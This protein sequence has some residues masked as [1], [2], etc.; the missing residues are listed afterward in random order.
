VTSPDPTAGKVRALRDAFNRSF[1]EPADA[2]RASDRDFLAIRVAG[3]SYAL[4]L[5]EVASLH[6]DQKLAHAPSL[7]PELLGLAGFRGTL[8]PIY[9]LGAVLG[10]SAQQNVRWLVLAQ[11]SSPIGFAF[12]SFEAQLRLS[13]DLVAAPSVGAS[14]SD[15][16]AI[17]SGARTLP[18]LHLPSLIEAIARR[19]NALGPAQER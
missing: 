13:L 19:I 1:A 5:S 4:R 16:G 8:A 11:H 2:G 3:D 10:Y 17:Q 18:L 15:H 14:A 12:E 6:A 9:D 7:L